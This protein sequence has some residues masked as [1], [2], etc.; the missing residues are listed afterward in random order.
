MK[1]L[2]GV[3]VS[4]LA[5]DLIRVHSREFAAKGFAFVFEFAIGLAF[6]PCFWVCFC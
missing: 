2:Q 4:I 6:G 1:W 5:I 3:V